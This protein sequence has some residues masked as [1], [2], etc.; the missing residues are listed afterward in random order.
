MDKKAVALIPLFAALTAASAFLK[1]P[2]WPVPITL[3]TVCVLLAG[4]VLGPGAGALSQVVYLIVGLMGLPVFAGGG[5]PAYLMKPSFGYLLGFVAAP[6]AVGLFLRHR[7]LTGI[8]CLLGAVLGTFMIYAVGV[9]YLAAYLHWV[10]RKPEVFDWAVKTG[11]LVFLP[12][13]ALKCLF[14]ALFVPRLV[15]RRPPTGSP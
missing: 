7:A 9:P 12:G 15:I 14:L 11:L 13:D 5:G 4:M 1:I 6:V 8:N 3:Q 2:L 10:I